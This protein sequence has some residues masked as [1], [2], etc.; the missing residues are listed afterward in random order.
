MEMSAT[1][2]HGVGFTCSDSIV[3]ALC[4]RGERGVRC[5]VIL[6]ESSCVSNEKKNMRGT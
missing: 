1:S 3:S 4:Y 5:S 2:V 6:V